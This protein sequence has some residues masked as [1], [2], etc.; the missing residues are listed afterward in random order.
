MT[1]QDKAKVEKP[2]SQKHQIKEG[3]TVKDLA[4]T[5]GIKTKDLVESLGKKGLDISINQEINQELASTISQLFNLD[6]ELIT[7]E[8]EILRTAMSDPKNL[9]P[10]PPVVTI[11]GHVDHGKTT[12][13]DAIRESNLI[14]KESGGI[15]QHIGA[16]KVVHKGKPIT[17]IDTPGHEAFTRLRSRGAN[18]TDIVILVVAAEDG[19]MPQTREAIDHAKA[20]DVP[21]IVAINKIDK[22]EADLEKTKQSLSKEDLLIEEWG[23][24]V[25]SVDISAKNKTN[26]DELLEMIVLLSDML[27]LKGNPHV[28]AQG[29]VLEARLD[30]KKGPMA[31]VII[32]HGTLLPGEAFLSGTCFGKARALLTQ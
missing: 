5:I 18:I 25:V 6:I 20:A 28:P 1:A 10:R 16:Y 9:V 12:L 29:V 31:T 13:L 17:F 26:L 7:L 21:I 4:D 32:Q 22:V 2:P 19:V 15:T 23:G 11:M 14:D 8:E 27:E 24:D 3:T 30:P